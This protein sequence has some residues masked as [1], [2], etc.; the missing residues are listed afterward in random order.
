MCEYASHGKRDIVVEG[1]TPASLLMLS[2]YI[3]G[4]GEP[5]FERAVHSENFL[6]QFRFFA[7]LLSTSVLESVLCSIKA[8]WYY[9]YDRSFLSL[10]SLLSQ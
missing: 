4:W 1:R 9:R 10:L 3:L 2:R 7:L 8:F 6:S 5:V